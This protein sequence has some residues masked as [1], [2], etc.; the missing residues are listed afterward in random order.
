[1]YENVFYGLVFGGYLGWISIFH[2]F[3]QPS[4]VDYAFIAII[5]ILWIGYGYLFV[6]SENNQIDLS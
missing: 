4:F 5:V 1:M 3:S 6:K 2:S